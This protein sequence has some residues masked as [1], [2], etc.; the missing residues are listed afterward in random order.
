MCECFCVEFINLLLKA[1][2]WQIL[3]T[4]FHKVTLKIMTEY[5]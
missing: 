1:K 4:C 3:K 2:V 5:F